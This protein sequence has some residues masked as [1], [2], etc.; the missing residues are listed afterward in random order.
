M[1]VH[2]ESQGCKD[3][4]KEMFLLLPAGTG[5]EGT[6]HCFLAVSAGRHHGFGGSFVKRR[7]G[8]VGTFLWQEQDRFKAFPPGASP[9]PLELMSGL[10]NLSHLDPLVP[11]EGA[12]LPHPIP[13]QLPPL[14][15]GFLF[16]S[17]SKPHLPPGGCVRPPELHSRPTWPTKVACLSQPLLGCPWAGPSRRWQGA[18]RGWG[19]PT[20]PL[21]LGQVPSSLSLSFLFRKM[22][23]IIPSLKKSHMGRRCGT[24]M[25]RNRGTARSVR[26]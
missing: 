7:R 21:K 20:S 26:R 2:L 11:R 23:Q 16:S 5:A 3:L 24:V 15:S 22:E 13:A 25:E 10:P 19:Q 18:V 14:G 4:S 17:L 12:D 8:V 1:Q 6:V 9:R